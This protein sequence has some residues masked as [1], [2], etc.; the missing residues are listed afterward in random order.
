MISGIF[1]K[2][3]PINYIILIGFLF[4]FYW[5]AQS[6]LYQEAFNPNELL[7]QTLVLLVL[8]FGILVLNFIVNRNQITNDNSYSILYFTLLII[9]FPK[10]ITD[11]NAI[12]SNFF[13]MLAS[14]R[15][16]S[17]KSLKEIKLKVLDA[18]LWIL[19]ASLFYDWAILFISLVFIAIYIYEPK[20]I[21][22]WL[23]PFVGFFVFGLL[24]LMMLLL[25]DNT[26]FF[27]DHY[28]F[29]VAIDTTW[30]TTWE[31]GLKLLIYIALIV[32]TGALVFIKTR[33]LGLGR[34][35]NLRIMAML[36]ALGVAVCFLKYSG[37]DYPFLITFFPAAV[38]LA[39]Y[40]ELIK[41]K[42]IKDIVLMVSIVV[43]FIILMT[44]VI[45]K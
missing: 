44:E 24:G 5:F 30:L 39:K 36:F 19:V 11:N 41:R 12:L 14:R 25:A 42:N 35:I 15:L 10:A 2:T 37:D 18:T 22:N 1:G 3:K 8:L 29:N 16:I 9:I 40:V 33:K 7:L 4:L 27:N 34:I 43:S 6:V 17:L 38:F 45:T 32:I 21:K 28:L 20:N 26:T 31:D 23:V 13:L